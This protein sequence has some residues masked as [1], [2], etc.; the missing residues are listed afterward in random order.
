MLKLNGIH[1]KSPGHKALA[2]KFGHLGFTVA[3]STLYPERLAVSFGSE[4]IFFSATSSGLDSTQLEFES[5]DLV[6]DYNKIIKLGL[7]VQKPK[8]AHNDEPLWYGFDFSFGHDA[9]ATAWASMLSPESYAAL[10]LKTLPLKHGNT[11]FG[12]E[13]L[14]LNLGN[15]QSFSADLAKSIGRPCSELNWSEIVNIKAHRVLSGNKFV[16]VFNSSTLQSG[17][18]MLTLLVTDLEDLKTKFLKS[19]LRILKCRSRDGFI[20]QL[21]GDASTSS[22]YLRFVRA[23]WKKAVLPVRADI[24]FYRYADSHRPLG[25]TYTSTLEGGFTDSWH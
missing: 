8:A 11:C 1:F 12:F 9:G 15:P 17:A 4:S 20:T 10:K 2:E 6:S 25:G 3:T 19:G 18:F 24:P 7:K 23:A 14:A 5:D 13:G 16:D 22:L 21:S